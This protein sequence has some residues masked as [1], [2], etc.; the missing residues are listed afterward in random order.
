MNSGWHALSA[1]KGHFLF[2]SGYSAN[3]GVITALAGPQDVILGDALN[4]AS[5]IDGCRLSGATYKTY[6]HCDTAALAKLLAALDLEGKK[7][8]RLVVT[9]TVFSMD[10]DLAPLEDIARLCHTHNALLIID[11]A[12][13]TGC[14]GPGGRGLAAH[15][16]I[17]PYVTVAVHTLSKALGGFGA[18]VTGS[19]LVYQYL[20]NVARPFLFTTALPPATIAAAQ[21][22][23]DLI[24][25]DPSRITEL[26]R[27]AAFL[28]THLKALGF[29]T[30]QSETHIIPLLVGESTTA[31]RMAEL[32]RE[33]GLYAVAIRPPTVPMGQA[34]IRLSVM[35]THTQQDLLFAVNILEKV[36]KQL[37][38]LQERICGE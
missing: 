38:L 29:H 9:E 25:Q 2:T 20:L 10:G 34:R 19:E 4:H 24:E 27:K 16:G 15:L 11:E 12:H 30:L 32:L 18:F 14:F 33:H 6:P 1:R 3:I 26:Q 37:K 31:L 21:A 7:G 23:L 36:G 17:T 22:A 13:A 35:A 28:R 5:I 8:V